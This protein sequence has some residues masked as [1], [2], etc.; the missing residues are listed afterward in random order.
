[1]TVRVLVN[2]AHG[3]MG[4]EAVKAIGLDANLT[5]AGEAD[6]D[7]DIT[8][9][10]KRTQPD[11]VVDLT[12]ASA[13][14]ENTQ[15]IIAANARPVIGTSGLSLEHV[16]QL[17]Q[18]CET[19]KLG[20]IIAPNFSIGGVLMM[21]YAQEAAKYFPNVE[22]IEFHHNKKA[23]APSGTSVRTA[24]MIAETRPHVPKDPTEH[25]LFKGA[26][27]GLCQDVRIHSVRIPGVLANQLVLFGGEGETL[28]IRHD[29][30]N[31]AAFMPG[32]CLACKKV[33]GLDRLVYGLEHVL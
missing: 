31:R 19:K 1:M 33:M 3:R 16:Q 23:D 29:T 12:T 13:A 8:D 11:V 15:K 9:M 27:G 30:L 17:T 2:G 14:F 24:E 25:E 10:I 7:D 5:L 21:R 20:G 28:E 18:Q 22:I 4:Q 32:I 26:R 6:K